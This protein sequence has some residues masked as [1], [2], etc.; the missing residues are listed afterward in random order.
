MIRNSPQVCTNLHTAGKVNRSEAFYN[1][2]SCSLAA[3]EV[4]EFSVSESFVRVKIELSKPLVPKFIK[5]L[6]WAP[7]SLGLCS[8]FQVCENGTLRIVN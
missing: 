7:G 4:D 8:R 3:A 1:I 2:C 6:Y 5:V